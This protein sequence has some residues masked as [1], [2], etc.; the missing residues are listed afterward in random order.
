MEYI[1]FLKK[2]VYF[3][4]KAHVLIIWKG[5]ITILEI[6]DVSVDNRESIKYIITNCLEVAIFSNKGYI[7]DNL[8][9]KMKEWN[10]YL[11]LSKCFNSDEKFIY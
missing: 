11:I 2:E 8:T 3:C 1:L 5:F 4:Y 10:I 6:V 7:G 9:W